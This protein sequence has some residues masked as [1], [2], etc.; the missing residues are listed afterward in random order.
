MRSVGAFKRARCSSAQHIA[1]PRSACR[2]FF[3]V[4]DAIGAQ[5]LCFPLILGVALHFQADLIWRVPDEVRLNFYPLR[6]RFD[7]WFGVT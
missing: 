7:R 4:A 2:G 6:D 1:T 5:G 3:C